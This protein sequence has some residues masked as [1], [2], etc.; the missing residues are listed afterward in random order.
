MLADIAVILM[1]NH[2]G[3]NKIVKITEISAKTILY[4]LDLFQTKDQV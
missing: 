3:S 4:K 2:K 1:E